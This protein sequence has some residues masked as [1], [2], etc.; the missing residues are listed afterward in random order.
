VLP[1]LTRTAFWIGCPVQEPPGLPDNSI[2]LKSKD[3]PVEYYRGGNDS[4]VRRSIDCGKIAAKALA[5][6]GNHSRQPILVFRG[7][8]ASSSFIAAGVSGPTGAGAACS[9]KTE[10]GR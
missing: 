2:H 4:I 6:P 10:L 3:T 7:F 1:Y 5:I 9:R 8:F